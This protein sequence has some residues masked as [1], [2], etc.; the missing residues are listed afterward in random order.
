MLLAAATVIVVTAAGAGIAVSAGG[1]SERQASRAATD[2]P[3]DRAYVTLLAERSTDKN[4]GFQLE[5]V[6]HA[7][8]PTALAL[9]P[10]GSG[11]G[12]VGERTGRVL[13]LDDGELTDRVVLDFTGVTET[14]GDGGLLAL[15]YDATGEWLYVYRT[16]DQQDERITAYPVDGEPDQ[17]AG[18]EILFIDHPRSEQHHGGGLAFGPD[19]HLYISTGDGGG[20]GDPRRNAQNGGQ[21]LGKVLRIEPTP[22]GPEPYVIP[23]DNPFIGRP[24]WQPEIW[25]LGLRNPFRLSF[26]AP[27]GDLWVADVGQSCWEEIDLLP[28]ASGG[29]RAA[30]LGWDRRE[31][32]HVFQAGAVPG[33]A[34]DPVHS[35]AHRDGWCAI[36]GGYVVRQPE[37]AALD[38]WY[39][40]TDFCGGD[41][42]AFRPG[43]EGE[44]PRLLDLG[45]DV[46]NPAAVVPGPDGLPWI[47]S[48]AGD[49]WRLVPA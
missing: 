22:A 2:R 44:P 32:T 37:L 20:L 23:P 34:V 26:D 16:T 30:N 1:T 19:G 36:V 11:D 21:L 9:A 31:G 15:A 41:L 18:R 33:G 3:C 13:A 8:Q 47:L 48:L 28:A 24:G 42:M 10:D 7:E 43:A 38:G 46:E 5:L 6:G 17:A 49:I 4:G 39:L 27:T 40:H 35:Y 29:G 25:S 12:V 45:V 14:G